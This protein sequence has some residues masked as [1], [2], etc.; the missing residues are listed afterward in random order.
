MPSKLIKAKQTDNK[1]FVVCQNKKVAEGFKNQQ[2]KAVVNTQW[3]ENYIK[4]KVAP[5][6]EEF[7]F[8]FD[9]VPYFLFD[10]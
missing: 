3:L 8:V 2:N 5:N 4:D 7:G 1:L 6:P 10:A 9:E